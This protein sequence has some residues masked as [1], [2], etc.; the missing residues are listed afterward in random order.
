MFWK[1]LSKRVQ[2]VNLLGNIY[3]EPVQDYG[4]KIFDGEIFIANCTKEISTAC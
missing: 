2:K 4:K 1:K 3:H